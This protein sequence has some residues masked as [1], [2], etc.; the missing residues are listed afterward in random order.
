MNLDIIITLY[1]ESNKIEKFYKNIKNEII[2]IN[3]NLIFVDNGSKDKTLEIL[4]KLFNQD[5]ENIKIISLSKRVKNEDAV[6]AGIKCSKSNLICTFNINEDIK[7]ITKMYNFLTE[8][9]DYDSF[10]VCKKDNKKCFYRKII[11]KLSEKLLNIT[12]NDDITDIKM[13]R[14][15]ILDAIINF[16][17]IYGYSNSILNL[18]GFNNYY[19]YSYKELNK[20]N[21]NVLKYIFN[22]SFKP[23]KLLNYIGIFIIIASMILLILT[24]ILNFNKLIVFGVLLLFISGINFIFLSIISSYI[25]NIIKCNNMQTKYILKE[26][27]GFDENYL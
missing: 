22:Y 2:N 24:F 14:R 9:N 19:D 13:F 21:E 26:K 5:D 20:K 6:Y 12:I 18:I 25:T 7:Y 17:D 3:Y 11:L 23:L 4:K 27:I 16:S 15:N 10:Y 1:N 8:N